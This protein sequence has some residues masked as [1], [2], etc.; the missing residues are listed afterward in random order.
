MQG[1]IGG[2]RIYA[3]PKLKPIKEAAQAMVNAQEKGRDEG[4]ICWGYVSAM[5]R[6]DYAWPI[7]ELH[8]STTEELNQITMNGQIHEA[9]IVY[10]EE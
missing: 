4:G 10:K 5:N 2:D 1:P 8:F 6:G 9:F 7:E 3:K